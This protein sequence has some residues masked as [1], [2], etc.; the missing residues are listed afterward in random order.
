M[1]AAH[2]HEKW[3]HVAPRREEC[4]GGRARERGE[5]GTNL[6]S[7]P[8]AFPAR[9]STTPQGVIEPAREPTRKDSEHPQEASLATFHVAVDPRGPTDGGTIVSSGWAS[10]MRQTVWW[11][12]MPFRLARRRGL[13]LEDRASRP[14]LAPG[15]A[16]R[17]SRAMTNIDRDSI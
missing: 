3:I 4:G 13:R 8:E 16:R 12:G 11:G 6:G 15:R 9:F 1:P 7:F 14:R 10:H 2:A 5:K 17:D